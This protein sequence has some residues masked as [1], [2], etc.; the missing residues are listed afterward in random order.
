M[1]VEFTY[2]QR[3]TRVSVGL[4]VTFIK[5]TYIWYII[6]QNCSNHGYNEAVKASPFTMPTAHL[7][8]KDGKK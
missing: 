3:I 2:S 7:H 6:S 8:A 1:A 5:S 4:T